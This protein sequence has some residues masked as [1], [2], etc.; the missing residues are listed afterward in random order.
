MKTLGKALLIFGGIVGVILL[1]CA[2][3]YIFA[4]GLDAVFGGLPTAGQILF[5]VF[6]G[7]AYTIG[8]IVAAVWALDQL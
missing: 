5:G 1:W 7:V 8:S 6:G 4:L 2:G 3:A